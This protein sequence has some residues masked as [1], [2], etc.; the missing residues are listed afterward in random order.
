M[1]ISLHG[2]LAITIVTVG[3]SS[4]PTPSSSDGGSCSSGDF[5]GYVNAGCS[6][7]PKCVAVGDAVA[8]Y[9]CSCEG[10]TVVGGPHAA[11]APWLYRGACE[12]A[13][14]LDTTANDGDAN[15]GVT[16]DGGPCPWGEFLLYLE[17][18]CTQTP[19]CASFG[20]TIAVSFCSCEG[21]TISATPVGP[22]EP[23]VSRGPCPDS[24]ASD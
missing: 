2:F 15:D 8:A 13:A 1:R 10:K 4:E 22:D 24:G 12:D 17:P 18:G 23:W 11:S 21:K 20:D 9:Y 5:L 14:R 7:V 16:S 3:C 6:E 19:K